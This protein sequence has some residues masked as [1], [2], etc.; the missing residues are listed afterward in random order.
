[1]R[2]SSVS[3]RISI[4]SAGGRRTRLSL[5]YF[6]WKGEDYFCVSYALIRRRVLR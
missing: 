3:V 1:M 4:L 2:R 5:G 6:S